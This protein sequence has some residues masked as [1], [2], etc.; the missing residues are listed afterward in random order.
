M[1]N[2]LGGG[3][4]CGGGGVWGSQGFNLESANSCVFAQATD[5]PNTDPALG[6]LANNGGPTQTMALPTGSPA[7]DTGFSGA[8]TADQRGFSRPVDDLAIANLPGGDGADVGAFEL[9]STSASPDP[10][11]GDPP[12]E[13]PPGGPDVAPV[14]EL[15]GK[16]KQRLRGRVSVN[17]T[18]NEDAT[19]VGMGKLAVRQ[20]GTGKSSQASQSFGLRRA[21]ATLPAGS[22]MTLKLKLRKKAL[23]AARDVGKAKAR[24]RVTA[25]DP[26]G[27]SSAANRVVRLKE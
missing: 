4:N 11:G 7:V 8:L 23:A 21:T 27:N 20:A 13:D 26:A 24:I 1:S 5:Q 2:P 14:V 18:V 15:S 3:G 17:V 16:T 12:S 22:T 9:Q 19:A 25:T 10:G 6:P